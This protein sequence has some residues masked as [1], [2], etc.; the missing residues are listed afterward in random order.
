MEEAKHATKRSNGRYQ[1]EKKITKKQ[2]KLI[3]LALLSALLIAM[4]LM[5]A[6]CGKDGTMRG[7]PTLTVET[8]QKQETGAT[9]TVDVLVSCLG[10]EIYPAASLALNFDS[11][12]LEFL[13][14]EEGNVMILGDERADGGH[15]QLPEWNVDV[16][17]SNRIGQI[18]VLYL[19]MT[20]GKYAFTQETLREEG[21]V[22][23]RLLFRVRGS[24][25]AGD[26]YNLEV[27]DAVF[28]ASDEN[29]SLAS[30]TGTLK[31][32]DGKVIVGGAK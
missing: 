22:L 31:T 11:S 25:A 15:Y 1:T 12:H 32:R 30:L 28:A 26:V 6:F 23:V 5:L 4:L 16:E 2:K 9:F 3:A 17:R 27:A 7:V 18:N 24:A 13:G 10:D 8:P 19:D 20:G 29:K 14:V 21:N